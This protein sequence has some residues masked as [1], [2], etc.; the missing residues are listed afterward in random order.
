MSEQELVK[1]CL[2][3]ICKKNGFDDLSAMTQRDFEL[4]SREVEDSTGILISISTIKR[5]LHGGFSRMPQTATLNA[6]SSY[7]GF[8]NWQDYKS[9]IISSGNT[10]KPA[11]KK[12][13]DIFKKEKGNYTFSIN[14]KWIGAAAVTI[15]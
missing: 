13:E 1:L 12:G 7:L 14:W 3:A 8:K 10:T 4:I 11:N 6:I 15:G 5:L 2:N 9:S